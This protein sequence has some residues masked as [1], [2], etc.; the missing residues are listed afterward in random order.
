MKY[1]NKHLENGLRAIDRFTDDVVEQITKDGSLKNVKDL[2]EWMYKVF[3]TAH[4]IEPEAHV[5]M[6]A[7][8]QRYTTSAIS[9]TI[10]LPHTATKEQ[11]E[12]VVWQAYNSGCKGMTVYRDGCRPNQILTINKDKTDDG[13]KETPRTRPIKTKGATHRIPT[14]CGNLYVTANRDDKGLCEV[15]V[16]MGKGGNCAA[17]Q[18]EAIARLISLSLRANVEPNSIIKQLDNIKCTGTV[19]HDGGK[20]HSCAD[21]IATALKN[22]VEYK[23]DVDYEVVDDDEMI[24]VDKEFAGVSGICPDCDN[25]LT[26]GE[27]CLKCLSCGWS[28][29]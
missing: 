12:K 11:I 22:E 26:Y 4:D 5:S 16:Q 9:K 29:C 6:Q 23:I 1:L 18:L 2:P 17:A 21:A 8:F 20:V 28:K 13:C 19:W 27:G 3:V 14:A 24:E 25:V 7:A 15:F 10:N